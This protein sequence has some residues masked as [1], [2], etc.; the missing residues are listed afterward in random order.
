M[1]DDW[2]ALERLTLRTSEIA[3]VLIL[4]LCTA[5]AIVLVL[6]P[7]DE[8]KEA[9]VETLIII[10]ILAILIGVTGFLLAATARSKQNK[11]RDN[12]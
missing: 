10:G 8:I 1:I 3:L 5:A 9:I 11:Q 7:S 4:V 6:T 12:A 2:E